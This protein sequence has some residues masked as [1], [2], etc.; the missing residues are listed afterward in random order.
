MSGLVVIQSMEQLEEFLQKSY[1]KPV[2]LYRHS[3]RCGNSRYAHLSLQ[4]FMVSF[5]DATSLFYFAMVRVV[6]DR[7][8]ANQAVNRLG[9]QPSTPQI[10]LVY[11]GKTFW[12]LTHQKINS[13]NLTSA[14]QGVLAYVRR[15][16]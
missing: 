12:Q 9:V 5:P 16:G 7:H 3:T 2:F 15:R 11:Q 6:E 1:E 8:I 14:A 13:I 10:I 4:K